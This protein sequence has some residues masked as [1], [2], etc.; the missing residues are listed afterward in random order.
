MTRDYGFKSALITGA[1]SGLG[2]AMS[3]EL[4]AVDVQLLLVGRDAARLEGTA[5]D[6]RARGARV[7]T[8]VLD[9]TDAETCAT[10]LRDADSRHEFDLVIA[11]AGVAFGRETPETVRLT[12]DTNIQGV[13]NTL[14]PIEA[15][16]VERG[17]GQIGLVSS[18]AAFRALGGP[19][20][21]GASKAWVRLYGEAL[22][23]RL[24][25]KGVGVTVICPG[26]VDTPMVDDRTR[27]ALGKELVPAEVAAR[28]SLQ[29]LA[30]N[31]AR[32]SFPAKAALSIWWLSLLPAW[33]TDRKIRRKFQ[34]ARRSES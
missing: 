6:C 8:C 1:S 22:R 11:N 14:I 10:V 15:S 20:G 3:R 30:R 7:E 18:L 29:A 19:P 2:A 34:E 12:V 33:F 32:V 9:V 25:R 23:N 31:A 27:A 24:A 28:R 17:G 26:F 13:L 21:Y 4:A 16:M 5:K